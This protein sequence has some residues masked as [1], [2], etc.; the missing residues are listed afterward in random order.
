MSELNWSLGNTLETSFENQEMT[1]T[2]TKFSPTQSVKRLELANR[3]HEG[4][5]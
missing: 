3:L 5:L 2:G 4:L 1:G